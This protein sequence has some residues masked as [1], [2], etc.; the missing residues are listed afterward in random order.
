MPKIKSMNKK[1]LVTEPLNDFS[2]LN[3][4]KEFYIVIS[5]ANGS[6]DLQVVKNSGINI[7]RGS[8]TLK[9]SYS[10]GVHNYTLLEISKKTVYL[11]GPIARLVGIY[12]VRIKDCFHISNV[13]E[14]L[15]KSIG[16]TDL[17]LSRSLW[18]NLFQISFPFLN[19]KFSSI[20]IN[21]DKKQKINGSFPKKLVESLTPELYTIPFNTGTVYPKKYP[22]PRLFNLIKRI[23]ARLTPK[24]FRP[25]SNLGGAISQSYWKNVKYDGDSKEIL[26]L[27]SWLQTQKNWVKLNVSIFAVQMLALKLIYIEQETGTRLTIK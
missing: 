21:M 24:R 14:N 11:F 2:F 6:P 3:E 13:P 9:V 20:V 19:L 25:I 22:F 18:N 17:G 10:N 1:I 12:S 16:Y 5:F 7:Y 23:I 8:D 27:M 26:Q 15:L 4:F